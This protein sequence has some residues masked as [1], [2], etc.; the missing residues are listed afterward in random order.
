MNIVLIGMPGS[1]KSTVGVVLAKRLGY[2]FID[3][4]LVIQERYG[5]L[6]CEIIEER[7]EKGFLDIENKVNQSLDADRTVI[8]TGGSA[9]YGAEAM[10]VLK[11]GGVVVY[12]EVENKELDDR[13]LSFTKRGVITNGKES[14]AEIYAE[15]KSLYERY[16][17]ITIHENESCVHS[18]GL[19]IEKIEQELKKYLRL[20]HKMDI[21]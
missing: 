10:Q 15:R 14:M 11:K 5:Q 8:A 4:D 21:V 17:D 1:G 12:L 2:H 7:G 6:L 13:V 20:H 3:S 9:V 19:V 16:A 18:V